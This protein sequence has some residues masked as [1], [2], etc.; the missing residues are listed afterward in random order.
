MD[1]HPEHRSGERDL[2]FGLLAFQNGFIDR[3]ALLAAFNTWVSDKTRPIADL[4]EEN[5]ALSPDAHQALLALVTAHLKDHED[6]PRKSLAAVATRSTMHGELEEVDDVDLHSLLATAVNDGTQTSDGSEAT[7]TFHERGQRGSSDR[8]RV[9]R[10]HAQGGLG[11]VFIAR[12]EELGREVALKRIRDRADTPD[13]RS[14]FVLEAEITG[15]LEHPNIVPVYS[16]GRD[17]DGR[18]FYAMR[19]IQGDSL[20]DA[21]A[22]LHQA[23]P[24][25][26][27]NSVAVRELIGRFIDVCQA[28]AYA[29]K[30]GVVHRDLKPGNIIL[31]QYGETLLIDWGLAKLLGQPSPE[32]EGASVAFKASSGS[33]V[34]PTCAGSRV[35]TP[36]FMSPEQAQGDLESLGPVTDVYGLGATLCALLTGKPPVS[37]ANTDELLERVCRGKLDSPR[38]INPLVPRALQAICLK[39]LAF[40]PED[41]YAS[42][43]ALADDLAR[44]LA[45]EPVSALPESIW[46]RL[47]RWTRRHRKAAIAGVLTLAVISLISTLAAVMIHRARRGE[48]RSLAKMRDVFQTANEQIS[49]YPEFVSDYAALNAGSEA[50]AGLRSDLLNQAFTYYETF[51]SKHEDDEDLAKEVAAAYDRLGLL[52][53]ERGE[54]LSAVEDLTAS[55]SRWESL[56]KLNDRDET[57]LR[58]LAA[59]LENL[60]LQFQELGRLDEALESYERAIGLYEGLAARMPDD[61]DYQDDIASL[62]DK[63][64]TLLA[65][66][67]RREEARKH[68]EAQN[69]CTSGL[70]MTGPSAMEASTGTR[71]SATTSESI[72]RS[73]GNSKT[74]AAC[75][76]TALT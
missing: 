74:P 37:G 68:Y 3:T 18:P 62:E 47:G 13:S 42:A 45:D 1:K 67:G 27:P 57:S 52:R 65:R 5:G 31:G 58:G 60:G 71:A 29:H 8:F 46:R 73:R 76:A 7:V 25:P 26:D 56:I 9:L 36:A 38:S 44:W 69:S 75:F 4:L 51:I 35:G 21:I 49:A 34:S 15:G 66:H 53:A 43:V 64:A 55:I 16:L 24:K 41:R 32:T 11:E 20:R 6:D 39:A 33:D 10:F 2:L 17:P 50:I 30:K 23:T 22:S 63:L 72:A 19:F 48:Q 12:D 70:C 54:K 59:A 61:P 28:I 40:R 14:R